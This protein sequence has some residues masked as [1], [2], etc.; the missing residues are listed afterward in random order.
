MSNKKKMSGYQKLK[1]KM[2]QIEKERDLILESNRSLVNEMVINGEHLENQ[3]FI[4]QYLD[5]T[6]TELE[7]KTTL[8]TFQRI[9][10]KEGFNMSRIPKTN[11]WTIITPDRKQNVLKIEN[12]LE[13]I[14]ALKMSGMDITP[15]GIMDQK[16][17]TRQVEQKVNEILGN[18]LQEFGNQEK[19]E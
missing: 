12:M 3:P 19:I 10:S 5:F 6:E 17:V 15:K 8:V 1:I 13:G 9:Y 18:T 14:N 2:K 4:P 11:W 16:I 7:D